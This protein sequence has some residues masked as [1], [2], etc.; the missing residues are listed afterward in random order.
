MTVSMQAISPF[1]CNSEYNPAMQTG[2]PAKTKRSD[3]GARL[4]AA[5][6]AKGLSQAQVADKLGIAQQSYAAWERRHVALTPDRLAQVAALLGISIDELLGYKPGPAR[7]AG[8]TGKA[9]QVFERVSLLPRA[10]QQRI[11]A[12][13]EDALTAYQVR[14]AG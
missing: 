14:K 6:E 3:F 4:H 13:V 2:R 7:P 5:R 9:R 12:N 8:P 10:T 11:L 1:T